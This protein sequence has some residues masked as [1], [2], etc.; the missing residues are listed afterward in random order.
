MKYLI[1]ALIAAIVAG[2]DARLSDEQRKKMREQ[3]EL[4]KI[5]K[6]SEVE[7]TEAAFAKGRSVVQLLKDTA[8]ADSVLRAWG[9]RLRLIKPGESALPIEQALLDAYLQ[10]N[11]STPQD[12][13]QQLRT[14]NVFSDSILYT[15]PIVSTVDGNAEVT[16]TWN[17]W[18][19]RKELV[20]SIPKKK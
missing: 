1:G 15:Q 18:L 16:A 17:L 19:S 13:V 14:Q 3:M 11:T 12:N 5:R 10:T 7:I 8:D 20:L 2:C 9:G 4:H 6:V